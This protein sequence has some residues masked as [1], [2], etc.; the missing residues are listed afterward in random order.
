M[1]SHSTFDLFAGA[2]GL[3]LA[4]LSFS[5]NLLFVVVRFKLAGDLLELLI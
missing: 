1:P 5:S 3:C 2:G 4:I